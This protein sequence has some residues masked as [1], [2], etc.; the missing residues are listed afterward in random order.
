MHDTHPFFNRLRRRRVVGQTFCEVFFIRNRGARDSL[1]ISGLHEADF[2]FI[3]QEDALKACIH[4]GSSHA[5]KLSAIMRVRPENFASGAFGKRSA[6]RFLDF[7]ETQSYFG[8]V[9]FLQ[10]ARKS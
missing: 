7:P 10:P 3:C 8:Q 4:N 1:T 2:P 6:D 5:M 9:F